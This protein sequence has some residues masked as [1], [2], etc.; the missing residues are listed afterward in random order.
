MAKDNQKE[1]VEENNYS[2]RRILSGIGASVGILGTPSIAAGNDDVEQDDFTCY[3]TG[4]ISPNCTT[5]PGEQKHDDDTSEP[6]AA[7]LGTSL[8][9][10]DPVWTG[11]LGEPEPY[12]YR[13]P[14][15]LGSC[16]IT[17]L[18]EDIPGSDPGEFNGVNKSLFSVTFPDGKVTSAKNKYYLGATEYSENPYDATDVAIDSLSTAIGEVPYMGWVW[19]GATAATNMYNNWKDAHDGTDTISRNWGWAEEGDS[20]FR[21]QADYYVRFDA[22]L[23]PSEEISITVTDEGRAVRADK[24]S[25]IVLSNTYERT[26]TAPPEPTSSNTSSTLH[27]GDITAVSADQV[28][29]NP[30][31]YGLAPSDVENVDDSENI[32]F[33][34]GGYSIR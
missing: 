27:T 29:N 6:V 23:D 21:S 13:I 20:G 2:R 9:Q 25:V 15:K 34:T 33:A 8:I 3:S 5:S 12:Y 32:R 4:I 30:H 24:S 7:E 31:K 16:I 17:H 18:Q 10:Y 26:I 14:F 11:D 22:E 1:V 28:K 19:S